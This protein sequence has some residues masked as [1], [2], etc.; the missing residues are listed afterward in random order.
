MHPGVICQNAAA[1]AYEAHIPFSQQCFMDISK[2][3][4]WQLPACSCLFD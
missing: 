3:Y 4:C 2:K 1:C